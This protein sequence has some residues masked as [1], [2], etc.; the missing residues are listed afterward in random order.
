MH[1]QFGFS[2][3]V[4][5]ITGPVVFYSDFGQ[6]ND[7]DTNIGNVGFGVGLVH[8]LNFS[9]RADCN[10]YTR[11]TYFNDH[12][13]VRSEIDFHK[14]NFEHFGEW[15]EPDKTSNELPVGI[16]TSLTKKDVPLLFLSAWLLLL[17]FSSSSSFDESI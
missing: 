9:Y 3:E 5:I 14:T 6:R 11:S 17:L 8:Y 7:F 4:G 13:K 10:C 1:G 16:V 2:H 15:V 12:F